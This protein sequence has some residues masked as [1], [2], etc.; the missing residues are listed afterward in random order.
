MV[1]K[2][3]WIFH[4][5]FKNSSPPL[6]FYPWHATAFRV[7]QE[8]PFRNGDLHRDFEIETINQIAKNQEQWFL[9]H[10]DIEATPLLDNTML[11][12]RLKRSKPLEL[13]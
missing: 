3:A 6:P 13:V 10:F 2:A 11:V 7:K 9:H 5:P 8:D 1:K 12:R 4:A